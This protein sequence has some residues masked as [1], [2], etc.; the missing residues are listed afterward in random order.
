MQQDEANSV[1]ASTMAPSL[2]PGLNQLNKSH[3]PSGS[4]F[5]VQMVFSLS[6]CIN[7]SCRAKAIFQVQWDALVITQT[8]PLPAR[9]KCTHHL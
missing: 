7:L 4:N 9:S 5:E 8:L 6:F 3:K 1:L 2:G